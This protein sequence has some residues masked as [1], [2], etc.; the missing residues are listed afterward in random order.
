MLFSIL[1]LPAA[2]A[3]HFYCKHIT[4]NKKKFLNEDGPLLIA[5]NHPNSFL[6]AIILATIFKKPVYSLAR[7]DAFANNFYTRL[8]NAM[9]ILPVY[10]ISE[11][12]ENL[13]HNYKTFETCKEIFKKNGVVLIFS[14]GRC[15]NEWHLRPLKKGTARLTFSSWDN[16]IP[17]KILPLGINYNSFQ[18]FG[19]TIELNFGEII[20]TENF[21]YSAE[22]F[23]KDIVNFNSR[24][25][26]Q[27]S[28][29]VLEFDI[30]DTVGIEKHFARPASLTKKILLCLPAA[31]GYLFHLPLYLPV[32]S[33]SAKA[34]KKNDHYDSVVVSLLMILYPIYLLIISIAVSFFIGWWS[35]L[36]FLIF[37]FTAW[38]YL[39]LKK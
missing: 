27:L 18:R 22:S 26:E 17:L 36:T 1:K 30:N 12:A 34:T 20:S 38:A 14:E 23:G 13:E 10:R 28:E 7:G 3:I 29:L 2:I 31:I 8:L 32:K 6:D 4:I 16:G 5:A 25:N 37:P 11:G 33:F 35:L 9:N 19:K 39:Q 15:I 24:L 21:K